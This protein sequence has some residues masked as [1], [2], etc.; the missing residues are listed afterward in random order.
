LP[1]I[2]LFE[3]HSRLPTRKP[4]S[5]NEAHGAAL[6]LQQLLLRLILPPVLIG[7]I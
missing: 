6:L 2:A 7:G 1:F 4:C 3:Y 5:L